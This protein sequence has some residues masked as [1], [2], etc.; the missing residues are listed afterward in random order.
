MAWL[1]LGSARVFYPGPAVELSGLVGRSTSLTPWWGVSLDVIEVPRRWGLALVV[2]VD[3][4]ETVAEPVDV[5]AGHQGQ[6]VDPGIPGRFGITF[7][8]SPSSAGQ[9]PP[10]DVNEK[11]GCGRDEEDGPVSEARTIAVAVHV[12]LD[13]ARARVL[14]D[15][16]WGGWLDEGD[17]SAGRCL[18]HG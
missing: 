3:F 16:G 6:G 1:K 15:A 10:D 18:A 2:D 7:F 5:V 9:E 4:G 13:E 14:L 12:H 11:Q 8:V 17:R